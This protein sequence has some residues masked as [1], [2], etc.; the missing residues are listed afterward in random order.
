MSRRSTSKFT[1]FCIALPDHD[2][3]YVQI[4]YRK[5]S[6]PV[7]GTFVTK[8]EEIN[9]RL[10]KTI[11]VRYFQEVNLH[12]L[13]E[14]VKTDVWKQLQPRIDYKLAIN[15][16]GSFRLPSLYDV[17]TKEG[18]SIELTQDH[19]FYVGEYE[20]KFYSH[21]HAG[22]YPVHQG[23]EIQDPENNVVKDDC[24]EV[25]E[26]QNRIDKLHKNFY[27]DIKK[28]WEVIKVERQILLSKFK[29]NEN[30]SFKTDETK[31]SFDTV[32]TTYYK[33]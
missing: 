31:Q 1:E 9:T 16:Q 26:L 24:E 5:E 28:L 17:V 3:L 13:G 32:L 22:A 7:L 14:K 21:S 19:K 10:G 18:Q 2:E 8:A 33:Q 25:Q 4:Y 29:N 6:N 20:N 27:D 30:L 23:I 15:R 11:Y 12:A